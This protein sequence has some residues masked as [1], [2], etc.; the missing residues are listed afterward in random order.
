MSKLWENGT[1]YFEA[2][3][4]Q[5]EPWITPYLIEDGTV[6]PC[7]IVFPGGGYR[8]RARHEADPIAQWLNEIGINAFVLEYRIEPYTH[9]AILGDALRAVRLVRYRAAEFNID[10]GKIGVLG[11]SAGGHLALMT[12]LRH[13]DADLRADD[14][15]DS[16]SSRPDLA[17]LCYPVVSF[18]NHFHEGSMERFLKEEATWEMRR[19]FSGEEIVTEDAPPMFIWHTAE[20][21]TVPVENSINLAKAMRAKNRPFSLHI[22]PNGS[23]G[24]GLARRFYQTGMWTEECARWLSETFEMEA[25]G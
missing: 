12:A 11:F 13:G 4:G 2:E 24:Q 5:E 15:V 22:Y 19:Q 9:K 14:P 18:V 23:H 10:P 25:E 6:H 8:G 3:Y 20:D 17:V 16:V 21:G 7:V 1:P